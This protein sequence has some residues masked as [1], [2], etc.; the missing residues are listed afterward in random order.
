MRGKGDSDSSGASGS[1]SE[2]QR[3]RQRLVTA[4]PSHTKAADHLSCG[5]NRLLEVVCGC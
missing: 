3:R 4:R 2:E 1:N 5:R